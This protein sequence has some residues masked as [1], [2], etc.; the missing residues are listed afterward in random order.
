[1]GWL[2]WQWRD[3]GGLDVNVLMLALE[4]RTELLTSIFGSSDKSTPAKRGPMTAEAFR[5]FRDRHNR[6]YV[7]PRRG[8]ATGG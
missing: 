6:R 4:G 5:S 1:M 7:S 2:G 3:I 8:R